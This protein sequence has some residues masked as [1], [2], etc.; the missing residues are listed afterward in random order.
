M[1]VKSAREQLLQQ[2]E[3]CAEHIMKFVSDSEEEEDAMEEIMEVYAAVKS[4][5]YLVRP[6]KYAKHKLRSEAW[7][8]RWVSDTRFVLYCKMSR[9][10]FDW[11]LSRVSPPCCPLLSISPHSLP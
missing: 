1:P 5:R 11:L 4:E 9:R 3:H 7:F 8:Q 10:S 6:A 2:L